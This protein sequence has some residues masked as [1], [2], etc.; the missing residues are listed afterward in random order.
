MVGNVSE[1]RPDDRGQLILIG[2]IALAFIL[3]GVVVVFNGVQYTQTI[4][5]GTA[6]QDTSDVAVVEA[7]LE[8]GIEGVIDR[9]GSNSEVSDYVE[10]YSDAKANQSSVSIHVKGVDCNSM[11]CEVEYRFDSKDVSKHGKIVV[12]AP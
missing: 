6:T 4:S 9:G 7:E 2:A 5:S 11:P 1:S 12:D 8:R 10:Y 3:L